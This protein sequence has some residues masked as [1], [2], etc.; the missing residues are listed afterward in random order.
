L[1]FAIHLNYDPALKP[2]IVEMEA[3][4]CDDYGL[5]TPFRRHPQSGAGEPGGLPGDGY[6]GGCRDL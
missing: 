6:E 5:K 4:R 1:A 3:A 2:E